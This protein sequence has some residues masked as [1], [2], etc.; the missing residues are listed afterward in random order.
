MY[1]HRYTTIDCWTTAQSYN[2]ITKVSI[3]E[4]SEKRMSC[5]KKAFCVVK[6]VSCDKKC[7][8]SKNMS[9]DKKLRRATKYH[10]GN[11]KTM[12]YD[13]KA[14]CVVKYNVVQQKDHVV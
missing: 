8:A 9:R 1:V 14:F 7:R 3:F 2:Y 13:K 11:K 5:D 4:R 12:L 6:N 10:V